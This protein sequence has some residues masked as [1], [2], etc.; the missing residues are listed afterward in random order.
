MLA[1]AADVAKLSTCARLMV[2]AVVTDPT[3]EQV[4]GYGYNGNASRL[5][6]ACDSD[7]PGRCGCVH[8]E[9]NALIKAGRGEKF[10]F[11]TVTPCAA[12][13]KMIINA[14]VVR[15]WAASWYRNPEGM[16]VLQKAGVMVVLPEV[17]PNAKR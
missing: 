10:M 15:V 1:F 2:G 14:D 13:A 7:E 17:E 11:L 4:L 9:T 16:A 3:M 8:A 5:P 6:N 12:C